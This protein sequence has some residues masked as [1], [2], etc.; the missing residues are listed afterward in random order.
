MG[1]RRDLY[2][3]IAGDRLCSR[4][5][6]QTE[7]GAEQTARRGKQHLLHGRWQ[8]VRHIGAERIAQRPSRHGGLWALRLSVFVSGV[9]RYHRT[10]TLW[11]SRGRLSSGRE[12]AIHRKLFLA[13]DEFLWP[14]G[15][16]ESLSSAVPSEFEF[17]QQ[18]SDDL[19][20][21]RAQLDIASSGHAGSDGPG[22]VAALA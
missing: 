3:W 4:A 10:S 7:C 11:L 6:D 16:S 19:G 22:V 8:S 13:A 21:G 12:S 2:Q 17:R 9:L 20:G 14:A 1:C 15:L 18:R 5:D